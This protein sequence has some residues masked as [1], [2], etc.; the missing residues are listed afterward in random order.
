M[1]KPRMAKQ[2]PENPTVGTGVNTGTVQAMMND[3]TMTDKEA[4]ARNTHDR[5]HQTFNTRCNMFA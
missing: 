5:K 3:V 1:M 4:S 2:M